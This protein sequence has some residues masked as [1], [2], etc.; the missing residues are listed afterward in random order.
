M[1]SKF[2]NAVVERAQWW[3]FMIC[4]PVL[5]VIVMALLAPFAAWAWLRGARYEEGDYE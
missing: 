4:Y 3:A 5:G 1:K 2:W